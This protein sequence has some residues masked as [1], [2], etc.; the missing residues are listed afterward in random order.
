MK[1]GCLHCT[2]ESTSTVGNSN[3]PQTSFEFIFQRHTHKKSYAKKRLAKH[4]Y[5]HL[6]ASSK[7]ANSTQLFCNSLCKPHTGELRQ[8]IPL[9]LEISARKAPVERYCWEYTASLLLCTLPFVTVEMRKCG[10]FLD[11]CPAPYLYDGSSTKCH[12]TIFRAKNVP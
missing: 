5:N 1:V 2:S 3:C 4:L 10:A 9:N 6:G 12:Q 8:G 7:I 11:V